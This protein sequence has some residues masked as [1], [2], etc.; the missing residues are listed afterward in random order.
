VTPKFRRDSEI[1]EHYNRAVAPPL[2]P[3]FVTPLIYRQ[4]LCETRDVLAGPLFAKRSAEVCE[5]LVCRKQTPSGE[6]FDRLLDS[7]ASSVLPARLDSV[8]SLLAATHEEREMPEPNRWY[9]S[10]TVRSDHE[11]RRYARRTKTFNNEEHAKLFARE[12]AVDNQRLTAGTI[13]PHSPKRVIS[14]TEMMAWLETPTQLVNSGG[15][16]GQARSETRS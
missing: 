13:N 6:P 9:V 14:P 16:T 2:A 4:I 1:S 11:P 8:K 10:Y 3:G 7:G 12:I 15:A 5:T